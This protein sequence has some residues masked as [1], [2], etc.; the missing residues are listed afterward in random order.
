[1]TS[2]AWLSSLAPGGVSS[3]MCSNLG[4]IVCGGLE[5]GR[6]WCWW[7]SSSSGGDRRGGVGG[8]WGQAQV[9]LVLEDRF[10]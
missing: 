9:G 4:G 8:C 6:W 10:P 7:C 2:P 5:I 3:A 1:M